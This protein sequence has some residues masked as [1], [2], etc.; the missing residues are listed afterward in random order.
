MHSL[1]NIASRSTW[2]IALLG[3]L[4][5]PAVA[6]LKAGDLLPDLTTFKLEGALPE[7]TKGKVLIVDFWASWCGP[8]KESF[9]VMNELA[10]KYADRGV[11]VIAVNV[12]ENRS[13]MEGFL[14]DNPASFTVVRDGSQKL[15]GKV[16]V[17]TM[18]SS[19]IVDQTGKVR[20]LH[21]GFHGE[22]TRKQYAQEIESL[23]GK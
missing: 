21:N 15:V 22:K 19:F 10:K 4:T 6:G 12:D 11:I 13:D 2:A 8:C 14:K 3:L 7:P 18:P 1:K 23:L 16:G 9:P 20:F 17:G 5:Q